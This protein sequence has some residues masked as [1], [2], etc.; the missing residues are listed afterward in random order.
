MRHALERA[1]EAKIAEGKLAREGIRL[2]LAQ[3][4]ARPQ[5]DFKSSYLLNG[6]DTTT[7]G[8]DTDLFT[9]EHPSWSVGLE[10]KV[11]LSGNRQAR[12]DVMTARDRRQQ[13]VL[14]MHTVQVELANA[15]DSG[16]KAVQLTAGQMD[17]HEGMVATRRKLLQTELDKMERGLS[18]S[19][20]VL[21]RDD[22]LNR[23]LEDQLEAAVSHEKAVLALE[24]TRGTLLERF[25]LDPMH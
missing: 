1:P 22:D 16:I 23:I 4:Q 15:L 2:D 19:R 9:G 14:E 10:M 24:V 5:L 25:G 7:D 17:E 12:S 18:T 6:L 11:P 13:A 21:Q 20:Q 3:N 8:S